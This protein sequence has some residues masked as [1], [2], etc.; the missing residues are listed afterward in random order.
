M[1][2]LL[3]GALGIA[4]SLSLA[5]AHDSVRAQDSSITISADGASSGAATG[6]DADNNGGQIILGDIS[7]LPPGTVIDISNRGGKLEMSPRMIWPPLLSASAPVAAPDDAPSALMVME[8]S[9]A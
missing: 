3:A 4:F 9:W 1:N 7:S 8:E 5:V 6:A 2:R